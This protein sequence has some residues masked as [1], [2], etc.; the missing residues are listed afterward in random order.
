VAVRATFANI[1]LRN[2]I[3]PGVEGGITKVMPEGAQMRVF[4]AAEEYLRRGT[5]LTVIA[6]K[7]YGCGSSRDW[8]AKGVAL[9]G[10][11]AVIAESFERIHRTNL[12]GMGVLPL[13]FEEGTTA[14]SLGLD[15]SEAI[16]IPDLAARLGVGGRVEARFHRVDGTVT[17]VPLMIRLDTVEDVEYWRHGGI[18]PL[19]WREYVTGESKELASHDAKVMPPE[20]G[21]PQHELPD[22]LPASDVPSASQGA[23]LG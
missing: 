15:G 10:V 12:V 14:E 3:V 13:Q 20:A 8:A 1:R 7:N 16:D 11:K 19:V 9:L 6:G 22:A 5:P 4:E 2:R 23:T 17:T 21:G 18:M